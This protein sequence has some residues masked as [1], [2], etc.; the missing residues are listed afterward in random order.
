MTL[1][2]DVNRF[3]VRSFVYAGIFPVRSG[4]VQL[5]FGK[6]A[7]GFCYAQAGGGTIVVWSSHDHLNC[8]DSAPSPPP[9]HTMYSITRFWALPGVLVPEIARVKFAWRK[10]VN[11]HPHEEP[12]ER[13]VME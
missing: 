1:I 3:F 6:P 10:T 8:V 13:E 9:S 11:F 5:L 2:R 7:T 12:Y 4:N